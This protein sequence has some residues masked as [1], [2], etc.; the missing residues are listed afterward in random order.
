MFASK[1]QQVCGCVNTYEQCSLMN[2]RSVSVFK[3]REKDSVNLS[4]QMNNFLYHN[5]FLMAKSQTQS[6]YLSC[7]LF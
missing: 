6:M 3:K 1:V 2:M 4:K 5:F 7:L